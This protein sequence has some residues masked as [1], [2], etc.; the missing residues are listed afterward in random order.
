MSKNICL[1]IHSKCVR[2]VPWPVSVRT[3]WVEDLSGQRNWQL[4]LRCA[5]VFQALLADQLPVQIKML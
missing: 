2:A 4:L 5:L 1:A 3:I